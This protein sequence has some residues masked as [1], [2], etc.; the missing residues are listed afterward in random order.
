MDDERHW[1]VYVLL[2]SAGARER[3][4]RSY[5]GISLDPERRLLQH[6]GELPGGAKSTRGG[7]PWRIGRVLG[8]YSSRGRAQQ[9]EA[10]LKK[11]SGVGRRLAWDPPPSD[12]DDVSA[13]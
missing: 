5:V 7:R 3:A 12:E 1:F 10:S 11:L 9:L 13:V 8:P 4:Q 6:N 2:S